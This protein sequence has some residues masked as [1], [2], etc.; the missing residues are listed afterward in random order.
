MTR[1]TSIYQP[2]QGFGYGK[3]TDLEQ[4]K[5]PHNHT[6]SPDNYQIDSF[7]DTNRSHQKG[8][9]AHIGRDVFPEIIVENCTQELCLTGQDQVPRARP[10]WWVQV[11]WDTEVVDEAS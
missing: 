5:H 2:I 8:M 6:P 7:V 4:G 10:V 9:S 1:K 11:Q 3:N